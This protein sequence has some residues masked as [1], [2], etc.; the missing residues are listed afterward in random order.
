M[1]VVNIQCTL[2]FK[3]LVLEKTK[4][5]SIEKDHKIINFK[6]INYSDKIVVILD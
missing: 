4:I 3:R 5:I 1:C 2:D 6:I